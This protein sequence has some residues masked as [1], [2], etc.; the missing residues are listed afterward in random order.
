LYLSIL[1]SIIAASPGRCTHS[2]NSER[3]NDL[4]SGSK[5]RGVA[6]VYGN[7]T[8][9]I[10]QCAIVVRAVLIFGNGNGID[11]RGEL[12]RCGVRPQSPVRPDRRSSPK[13]L[14][15]ATPAAPAAPQSGGRGAGGVK[16]LCFV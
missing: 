13:R 3:L 14:P 11:A 10:V 2:V 5:P 15:K 16:E 6:W 7:C 4:P 12:L 1:S 9:I 8:R